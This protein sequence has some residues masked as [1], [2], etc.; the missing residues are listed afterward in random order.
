MHVRVRLLHCMCVRLRNDYTQAS[1]ANNAAYT[2]A[3][4]SDWA[5]WGHKVTLSSKVIGPESDK[6]EFIWIDC[7]TAKQSPIQVCV[8]EL[9]KKTPHLPSVYTLSLVKSNQIIFDIKFSNTSSMALK[10]FSTNPNQ[11]LILTRV[12]SAYLSLQYRHCTFYPGVTLIR[13]W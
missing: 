13:S 6:S 12:L 4:S 3:Q 2:L 1:H 5:R 7:C 11:Q 8:I 10:W 9:K